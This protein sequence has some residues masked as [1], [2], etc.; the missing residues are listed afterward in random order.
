[1]N[2]DSDEN[3]IAFMKELSETFKQNKLLVTM[4]MMTDNDD[5]NIQKLNPYVDYFVLMAYDEYSAD[6]DAGPISSQKWIEAQT[7][8][9]LKKH[10]R[11]KL[12]WDW[13]LMVTTGVPIRMITLRNVYAGNYKSHASKAVIN[14]DDNTFNLNYSYTDS[15]KYTYRIFQ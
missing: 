13:E 12:F 14:F 8:K 11:T 15:K 4:D 3:L 5:Y 2:L 9:F 6:S 10:L 1:M 7:G